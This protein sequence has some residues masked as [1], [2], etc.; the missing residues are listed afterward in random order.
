ML[1]L[2]ALPNDQKG[3]RALLPGL[4]LLFGPGSRHGT[5]TPLE[6]LSDRLGWTMARAQLGSVLSYLLCGEPLT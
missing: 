1:A 2:S 6:S 5:L 3:I 4:M